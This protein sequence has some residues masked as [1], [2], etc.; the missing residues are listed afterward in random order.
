[1]LLTPHTLIGMA[2]AQFIGN[3]FLAAPICFGAHFLCDKIPHWDLYS[4]TDNDDGSRTQGWR[5]FGFVVDFGFAL[6]LGWL[7]FYRQAFLFGNFGN[8]V[9][10]ISGAIF[11]NLPDALEAPYIFH[12]NTFKKS[13]FLQKFT[14]IQ[15]RCQTQAPPLI[16]LA[17]QLAFCAISSILL[18]S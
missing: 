5:L 11:S 13:K 12:M 16:G 10:L 4:N 18:L 17:I 3:P 2:I 9:T 1:M 14:D 6:S 15:K 7:L 8:A